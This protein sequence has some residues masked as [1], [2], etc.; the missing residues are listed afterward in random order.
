[1]KN[2][3]VN[4]DL[5]IHLSKN[6]MFKP[7]WY[8]DCPKYEIK[9]F[10]GVYLY[11]EKNIP[12]FNFYRQGENKK[13]IIVDISNLGSLMQYSSVNNP[14][15]DKDIFDIFYFS[16]EA[17]SENQAILNEMLDNPP[18]WLVKVGSRNNQEDYLKSKVWIRIFE[19]FDISF[20]DEFKGF[21]YEL[22]ENV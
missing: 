11:N 14:G 19:R 7:K 9:N 1:L 21:Y 20:S 15:E 17:F 18:K 6:K 4:I 16:I 10:N 5:Y 3:T 13:I 12:V 22:I 8:K 2:I